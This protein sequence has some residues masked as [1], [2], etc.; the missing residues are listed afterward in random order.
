M[1]E[2]GSPIAADPSTLGFER[3]R[4][5]RDARRS[6]ATVT[7]D[8]PDVLNALDFRTLR[9]LA[10]AFEQASWD[11]GV[12]VV[13]VTG[14]G[15]RSFCTGADLDEQAAMGATSGQYWRWMGAFI[16]MHDRLRHIGKPTIARI[17]G[18]CVGGGNELQM[19]CDLS[20]LVDDAY[21][22]HV[23]PE[24]GSVPAGGATQ[25]LPL[26]VGDRRAREIVMLCEPI[27]AGDRRSSGG[28]YRGW[29]RARTWT[30][31]WRRWP[32]TWRASCRRR[33]A[34]PRPSSTG[35][36][37]WSGR[38]RSS[39]RATGWPSTRAP[40]RPARRSPPS[41]TSGSRASP[42]SVASRRGRAA[43]V[44]RAAR[45]ACPR[46]IGSAAPAAWS[47]RMRG[48]R[49]REPMNDEQLV[50]VERQAEQRT[51][52]VRLNR[53]KQLNALNGAV[54]DALCN[55]L[56]E[57]DRDDEVRAIV[58]TGNERAFAAGADIGEMANATPVEMLRTNRI[59]Q[60]DRIRK[61]TKPVIAAVNGWA[62]GGGCELAM[63]LDLIVAGEGA[64][65]GQPEINLGVIPGAGGTQRLTRAVGKSRAMR[66]ILTGDPI[67]AAEAERAGLVAV[68]TQDELVV[69]DALALAARIATKSPIALRLAKEA[70]NAAYEM[71]LTDALA[72]ERRLFYLLFASDDQKEG[73][74]A[75]LEKRE[76][77]F[78]GR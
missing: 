70:I 58:V 71:S 50:L 23:G 18:I 67:T 35:G 59:G 4:Y 40:M 25:W 7:I 56:E 29:W 33:C 12:A 20:V 5:E 57:L 31:P 41:T 63:A 75:F 53:P 54:M 22:R 61:V 30:P 45:W 60:W 27:A 8:R 14:A 73:M 15:D 2:P 55:A 43:C 32:T 47:C 72:H 48:A 19:A 17:N 3:I 74:A 69:E 6:V 34:T 28:W 1:P 77:D 13:V 52:L 21:I 9:E 10:R 62:L 24:H 38:R 42:S 11:D 46:R 64:K 51:A 76:P 65:F 37:T 78:K 39:T 16:E 68:V 36:A 44:P 49:E 26:I 66:M